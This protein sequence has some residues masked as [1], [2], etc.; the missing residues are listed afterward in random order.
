MYKIVLLRKQK[1]LNKKRESKT[2]KQLAFKNA[3][4]KKE[5]INIAHNAAD[6]VNY[7]VIMGFGGRF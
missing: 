7:S 4:P 1:E 2:K 5:A 6:L 3:P